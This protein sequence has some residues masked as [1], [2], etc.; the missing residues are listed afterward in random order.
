MIPDINPFAHEPPFRPRRNPARMWTIAAVAGAVTLIA[1]NAGLLM[2]GGIDGIFARLNGEPV[3][4]EPASL[5]QLAP[6]GAP[7]RRRLQNGYEILTVTGRIDNPTSMAL[8]V[9][10]IRAELLSSDGKS[11]YAW[12]IAAPARSIGAGSSMPFDGVTVD[13]PAEATRMRLS[14]ADGSER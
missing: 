5:L 11:V 1:L 2:L 3:V 10:D 8:A 6:T 7:E 14:F 9:P 13:V 12:T 4:S